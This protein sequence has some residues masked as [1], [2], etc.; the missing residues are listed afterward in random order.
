MPDTRLSHVFQLFSDQN[1]A[2]IPPVKLTPNQYI[3]PTNFF[4][5][6]F[7]EEIQQS[8]E[9]RKADVIELAQEMSPAMQDIHESIIACMTTTLNE[10]KRSNTSV[11]GLV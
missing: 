7:H 4:Q 3:F 5:L 10:L 9:K 8:L 2:F 11:R 6:R 1:R